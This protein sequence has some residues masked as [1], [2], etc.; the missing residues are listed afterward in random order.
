M[1][2]RSDRSES[3]WSVE[4]D[5]DRVWGGSVTSTT[6]VYIWHSPA[7]GYGNF[8]VG[9]DFLVYADRRDFPGVDADTLFVSFC[10]RTQPLEGAG[11][12]LQALGEGQAPEPGI[13]GADPASSAGEEETPDPAPTSDDPPRG[14]TLAET[15]H[16]P[17]FEDAD[18]PAGPGPSDVATTPY[19]SNGPPAWAIPLLA[20]LVAASVLIR[21]AVRPRLPE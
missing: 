1:D 9:D 4:F 11:E 15:G 17:A 7:C 13:E 12:D 20:G 6:F 19:E 18:R 16:G 2:F 21:L 5:V 10:S 14:P 8:T 3:F